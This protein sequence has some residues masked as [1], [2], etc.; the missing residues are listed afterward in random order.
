M[1][2]LLVILA[3][4]FPV[5]AAPGHRAALVVGKMFAT[6][7]GQLRK[8]DAA[9]FVKEGRVF[10]PVRYLACALGVPEK[11]VSWAGKTQTVAL[12]LREERSHVEMSR[13]AISPTCC[14]TVLSRT[15]IPG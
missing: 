11:G 10:L 2:F 14:K 8:L 1:T 15:G 7:D 4:A 12:N 13:A 9:P 6:V 3:F 5:L